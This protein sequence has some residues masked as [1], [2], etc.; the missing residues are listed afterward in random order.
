MNL[1][2]CG[3]GQIPDVRTFSK[4]WHRAH[5]AIHLDVFPLAVTDQRTVDNL[6][7]AIDR[8]TG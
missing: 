2:P 4:A 7:Q 1:C 6:M 8:A 3:M 5:L